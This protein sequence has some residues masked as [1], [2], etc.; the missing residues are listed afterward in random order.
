M[1]LLS[2]WRPRRRAALECPAMRPVQHRFAHHFVKADTMQM[3]MRQKDLF[4]VACY[5][6]HAC[7][8]LQILLY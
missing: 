6:M 1:P 4:S 8:E 7:L 3:F 5:I 2:A